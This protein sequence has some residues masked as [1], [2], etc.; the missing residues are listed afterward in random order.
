MK[1]KADDLVQL[2]LRE[3]SDEKKNELPMC[4]KDLDNPTYDL[5]KKPRHYR[6]VSERSALRTLGK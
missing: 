3:N 5:F 1:F 4:S 6:V 2:Y